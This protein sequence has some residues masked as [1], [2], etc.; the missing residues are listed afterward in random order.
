M[1]KRR[2]KK[3]NDKKR[4]NLGDLMFL[5]GIFVVIAYFYSKAKGN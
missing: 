4:G 3:M 5:V 1:P 2:R